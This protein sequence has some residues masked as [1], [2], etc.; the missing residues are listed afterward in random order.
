MKDIVAIDFGMKNLKV[1]YFNGKNVQPIYVD[2]GQGETIIPNIVYYEEEPEEKRLKKYFGRSEK[3]ESGRAVQSPDYIIGIKRKLQEKEWKKD[4][5]DG[6]YQKTAE[7]IVA[8]IFENIKKNVTIETR[9]EKLN[10]VMTVPVI[11][12]EQQKHLLAKCAEKAG[13]QVLEVVTEPFASLFS[14]EI[15][16]SCIEDLDEEKYVIVFDFGGSTLDLCMA[17]I[18]P[19][20]EEA[21]IAVRSSVGMA[22]GGE[23]ISALIIDKVL[24]GRYQL[25]ILAGQE[26]WAKGKIEFE[27]RE[28]ADQL[29]MELYEDED[30]SEVENKFLG[31]NICLKKNAVDA[32]LKEEKLDETVTRMLDA[33]LE[34]DDEGVDPEDISQIYMIGGSSRVTFFQEVIRNYFAKE[35]SGDLEDEDFVYNSVAF[36]AARYADLRETITIDMSIPVS[37]CIKRGNQFVDM[38]RKNAPYG[39]PGA[40]RKLS[41]EYLKALDWAVP[42]YQYIAF[43]GNKEDAS[44]VYAG[45]LPLHAEKYDPDKEVYLSLYQDAGGIHGLADQSDERN[46]YVRVETIDLNVEEAL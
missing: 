10:V 17:R 3:A 28:L 9:L 26:Q 24:K 18:T 46:E 8:D 1:A 32:I 39:Q 7:E 31:E 5:C 25:D 2:V 29:K 4:L 21:E 40:N 15:Y 22:L 33:L 38:L 37:V 44:Y 35:H 14:D 45:N 42:V 16:D 30:T 11:F 27:L 41:I 23:D 20:G 12:S 43:D 34:A 13:F 6:R 36:G 19:R